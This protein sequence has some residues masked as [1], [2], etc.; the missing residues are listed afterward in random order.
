MAVFKI[1]F[2]VLLLTLAPL[3]VTAQPPA[4]N[5]Q[6]LS[7]LF[8]RLAWRVAEISALDSV[9]A[10]SL[11][12]PA[13][14]KPEER[15]FYSRL[16]TV[17]TDSL[18]LAVFAEPLD[19]LQTPALTYQLSRCEIVYQPL[20]RRRF[21]RQRRWRRTAS[22]VAE[23]GAKNP[24][25]QQVLFQKIFA[26]SAA[27]TLAEKF[28]SGGENQNFVFTMGRREE[29]QESP[30]WLEPVLITSATGVVVYLFYSLRS[31]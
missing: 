25:T 13:S 11:K 14:P 2:A 30:R 31:R 9:A 19:S 12:S 22:V 8:D 28:L 21:W 24:R 16:L 3:T 20:P 23:V 1:T 10:V 15:F 6:R 29:R 5:L 26:E 18:R 7:Q 17:L 4:D 27:D